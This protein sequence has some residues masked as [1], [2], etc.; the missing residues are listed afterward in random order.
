MKKLT[1]I[2]MIIIFSVTS[3]F[4][5]ISTVRA[6]DSGNIAIPQEILDMLPDEL[7]E[8]L[9]NKTLTQDQY[10]LVVEL[11][12]K[13]AAE[14]NDT[15]IADSGEFTTFASNVNPANCQFDV[16]VNYCFRID[17]ANSS[18]KEPYHVHI[19]EKKN[20]VYCFRLNDFR[21]CDA[22]KNRIHKFD[23]LPTAV[24]DGVMA[25][26]KV[27]ERVK[28]YNPE[29]QKW[30]DSI[31][32]IKNLAIAA[33]VVLLVFTP[34]PGDEYVAWAYFLRAIA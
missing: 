2:A 31:P 10:D 32:G 21:E 17:P 1:I 14:I 25:N 24:K 34:I 3:L 13:E 5:Q 20:H 19:Y 9:T 27:Q 22:G 29:A 28:I 12:E 16:G 15:P 30:S 11:M 8:V 18:T 26:K 4:G 6:Q 23:D 7:S 33:I